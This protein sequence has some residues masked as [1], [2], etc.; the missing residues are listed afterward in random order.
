MRSIL[1]GP[2]GLA[3]VLVG[4]PVNAG[5]S[6]QVQDNYPAHALFAHKQGIV[7][8][9]VTVGTNGRA[10]DC[11]VTTSSGFR[12]LDEAACDNFLK[13]ALFKPATDDRGNPNE[14]TY[15][16]HITYKLSR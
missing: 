14:G 1:F 11:V 12:E 2:P 10:K 8:L 15:S 4:S 3:L 16:T 5:A 9:T 6:Y 7:Q 13:Y